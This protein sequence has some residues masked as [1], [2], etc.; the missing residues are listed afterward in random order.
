[1]HIFAAVQ[2]TS[3]PDVGANLRTAGPLIAQ[4]A[5]RGA[6]VVLL[7][8]N[9]KGTVFLLALVTC[10]SVL[11]VFAAGFRNFQTVGELAALYAE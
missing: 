7:P 8:E 9:F 11:Y 6:Q 10:A 1:M 5:E 2:M 3:G 4:A